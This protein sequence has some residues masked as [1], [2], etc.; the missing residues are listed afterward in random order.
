MDSPII[1]LTTDWGDRDF[2]AAMVKG[3]LCSLIPAARIIDL[4]HSQTRGNASSTIGIIRHGCFSFPQGTIHLVDVGV[5]STSGE[6]RQPRGF[7]K[8]VLVLCNG[9]FFICS[10]R[11]LLEQSLETPCQ[12]LVELPVTDAWRSLT[13]SA[14]TLFC[15]VV[16]RIVGGEQPEEIGV[17]CPPLRPRTTPRAQVD[18][19]TLVA[20][21]TGIDNYGNANLNVNLKEFEEVRAGRSFRVLIDGCSTKAKR[22][23]AL[24]GI[25]RHYN[26]ELEGN[27]LLTVSV[28]GDLQLAINEGSAAQLRGIQNSTPCRF[29]FGNN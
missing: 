19:N 25:K 9:H 6:S 8:P 27:L 3:R 4:S 24:N 5:E 1:T 16:R 22:Y 17:P 10:E 14:A 28:T 13:F 11:I 7:Q 18:G 23:E 26:E 21:V 15:D 12:Q 2:F 20:M 29:V